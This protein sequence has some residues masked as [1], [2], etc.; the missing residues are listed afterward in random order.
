MSERIL[1]SGD[2]SQAKCLLRR[3][4][5]LAESL[6][7]QWQ[8]A[9]K[10]LP[11]LE[12]SVFE[13]VVIELLSDI[14][15][16]PNFELDDILGRNILI[17]T[18]NPLMKPGIGRKGLARSDNIDENPNTTVFHSDL[19][20]ISTV[21]ANLLSHGHHDAELLPLVSL[22]ALGRSHPPEAFC[23]LRNTNGDPPAALSSA[24]SQEMFAL[25]NCARDESLEAAPVPHLKRKRVLGR[26]TD[27]TDSSERA[28][29]V[30]NRALSRFLLDFPSLA[31]H[32]ES[33]RRE[34][35]LPPLTSNWI[36]QRIVANSL[37]RPRAPAFSPVVMDLRRWCDAYAASV[38]RATMTLSEGRDGSYVPFLAEDA[39]TFDLQRFR[40]H[41]EAVLQMMRDWCNRNGSR[42]DPAW[43]WK[44]LYLVA[45]VWAIENFGVC[46]S[47]KV[48]LQFLDANRMFFR[49]AFGHIAHGEDMESGFSTSDPTTLADFDRSKLNV[50]AESARANYF[51]SNAIKLHIEEAIDNM[52]EALCLGKLPVNAATG[53]KTPGRRPA[54]R[55]VSAPLV[56]DSGR[57]NRIQPSVTSHD[58][59]LLD[60]VVKEF[61]RQKA[62]KRASDPTFSSET[63]EN[64]V[65]NMPADLLS[66]LN[67]SPMLTMRDVWEL[68]PG[69][70]QEDDRDAWLSDPNMDHYAS[71]LEMAEPSLKALPS[72][73]D[74]YSAVAKD[75]ITARLEPGTKLLAWPMHMQFPKHWYA[76]VV[77][78][79]GRE[80]EV[81]DSS[82]SRDHRQDVFLI[83]VA[84][85][86]DIERPG[87][88]PF[89]VVVYPS[90]KQKNGYDCGVYTLA[91]LQKRSTRVSALSR[92]NQDDWFGLGRSPSDFRAS[93]LLA[94][95]TNKVS[96][97]FVTATPAHQQ[98]RREQLAPILESR[99]DSSNGDIMDMDVF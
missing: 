83:E 32:P 47:L 7:G 17:N 37:Y 54:Q 80:V 65:F 45:F 82:P 40:I 61:R 99:V 91:C 28:R 81:Y 3:H 93:V 88:K 24:P 63:A 27:P 1:T 33:V 53:L 76:V 84:A 11:H 98:P 77:N 2:G 43:S 55:T 75:S 41:A 31:Y 49:V 95:L 10:V 14:S 8:R 58:Q 44:T 57:P 46:N 60:T 25:F 35:P 48:P 66:T 86:L 74:E 18:D 50:C 56:L 29:V 4:P 39:S 79:E 34:Q 89:Q 59:T 15:T 22:L 9:K 16:D 23:M 71:L 94:R 73:G 70:C 21:G 69:S 30:G 68:D 87:P 72:M 67:H 5:I 20:R 52:K 90:P 97:S 12:K 19:F 78:V 6:K 85:H 92:A 38:D 26:E 13:D 51:K 42:W 64:S 36:Q 96:P 62:K